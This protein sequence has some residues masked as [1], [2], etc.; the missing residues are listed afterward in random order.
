MSFST[1][2]GAVIAERVFDLMGIVTLLGLV[3]WTTPEVPQAYSIVGKVML[4]TLAVGY[5]AVLLILHRREPC[6]KLVDRLVSGLP[7]RFSS[8][9]GGA[10]RRLV[11][12]LGIMGSA[13]LA[14]MVFLC[15]LTLWTLFSA[16]TYLFL[17]AFAVDAPF[18]AA[19]TIQVLLCF[20]VALPSAPGF[21]GTFHAVG[22]YALALF[23]VPA[24]PA[25]S[26][27]TVYHFFSL[28]ACLI[29]GAASYWRGSFSFERR[30]IEPPAAE[31]G[32]AAVPR[33][34]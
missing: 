17:K 16:L 6:Q 1:G 30:M 5:A 13:K 24:A 8:F 11:D 29:L 18:I 19:I 23:G 34:Q 28:A 3:L 2:V 31:D 14:S 12:G 7:E 4:V 15:S 27:A 9:I 20:G 32:D 33:R 21:I 26:F 10:F 25:I 22:R